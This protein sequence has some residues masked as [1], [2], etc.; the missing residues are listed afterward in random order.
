MD[1]I[2]WI[3]INCLGAIANKELS[4]KQWEDNYYLERFYES[5]VTI[6]DLQKNLYGLT[7][8][9]LLRRFQYTGSDYFTF[10]DDTIYLTEIGYYTYK[11]FTQL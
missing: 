2:G 7:Y 6:V 4:G 10:E 11:L 3:V 9:D 1:D 8:V 5:G